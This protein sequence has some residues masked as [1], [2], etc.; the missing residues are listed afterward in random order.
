MDAFILRFVPGSTIGAFITAQ[1]SHSASTTA[2]ILVFAAGIIV[3]LVSVLVMDYM[4]RTR[5]MR[6]YQ[7]W[8]AAG[9][10]ERRQ[11]E[12]RGRDHR[13]RDG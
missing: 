6:G 2:G 10:P 5:S 12:R 8:I 1:S 4:V 13:R 3:G 9:R 7:A 11:A